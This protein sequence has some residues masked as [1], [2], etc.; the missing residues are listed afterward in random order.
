MKIHGSTPVSTIMRDLPGATAVFESLGIDYACAGD[1]SLDD[2]AH[3]EGL[4]P[5]LVLASLRRIHEAQAEPSWNDRPLQDLIR[6]LVAAHHQFVR[7]ELASIALQLSELCSS[8]TDAAGE[9]TSLRAA[10]TR[11]SDSVLPHLHHEEE[12]VFR[13]ITSLEKEWQS[14]DQNATAHGDLRSRVGQL[15]SDHGSITAQLR[16]LRA[17]RLRTSS[18]NELTPR[19]RSVLESLGTLEAHLHEYMFLENSILFPRAL[20][21]EEQLTAAPPA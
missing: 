20:A 10:F 12:G 13:T 21:L 19:C 9:F 18:S 3:A 16:T 14:G 17:L 2:A 8:S 11:L 1:R 7:G 15:V 6:H 4:D 5:E